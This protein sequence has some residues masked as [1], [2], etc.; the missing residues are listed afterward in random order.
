MS[1][2]ELRNPRSPSTS[3]ADHRSR[4]QAR[5]ER[6]DAERV[7]LFWSPPRDASQQGLP[8]GR[9]PSA[10]QIFTRSAAT[11]LLSLSDI[12]C[13]ITVQYL[14]GCAAYAQATSLVPLTIDE[15]DVTEPSKRA[16]PA[17]RATDRASHL[18]P[19]LQMVRA[20]GNDRR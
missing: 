13:W 4:Q 7:M 16:Q 6:I 12:L 19:P 2:S 9:P 8:A 10:W 14:A 1:F 17:D 18:V 20:R 5:S 3:R 15:A 11:A